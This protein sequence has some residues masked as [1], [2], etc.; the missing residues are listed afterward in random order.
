MLA[1]NSI[2]FISRFYDGICQWEEGSLTP[3]LHIGWAKPL[4]NNISKYEYD[5]RSQLAIKLADFEDQK[6][7]GGASP[8]ENNN[9][10]NNNIVKPDLDTAG[11][12]DAKD[13][14]LS[15]IVA[16]CGE[17][18]LNPEF[19]LQG[20]GKLFTDNNGSTLTTTTATGDSNKS[21]GVNNCKNE[22]NIKKGESLKNGG[23]DKTSSIT[24]EIA[25]KGDEKLNIKKEASSE[26]LKPAE[27]EVCLFSQKMKGLREI[28]LAE[29]LNTN[30]ISLQITA[31]SQVSAKKSR[32][33]STSGCYGSDFDMT[34]RP[35][36]ARRD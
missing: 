7:E 35:K 32:G 20:G 29:K 26:P 11:T 4:V 22:T 3:I 17:K 24:S 8:S 36:R 12:K 31:Q 15:S 1:A 30:A 10:N 25:T 34:S 21:S 33:S 5:V 13:D 18:I 6:N 9:N 23:E 28:F 16:A 19:L 14:K 27:P 2:T